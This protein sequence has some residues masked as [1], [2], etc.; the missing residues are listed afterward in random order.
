MSM[1]RTDQGVR[2]GPVMSIRDLDADLADATTR[3]MRDGHELFF[4]CG[5]FATDAKRD[6]ANSV[7]AG[8][9]W[10][11]IDCGSGK[12]SAGKGYES[13]EEV[14][15]ELRRFCSVTG[16]PA[17]THTVNSGGGV[18]CYWALDRSVDPQTWKA[19]AE[20][21]KA[22][23][24]A[25]RLLA[26][27]SRTAD[28][29]SLMRLPGTFN[30]KYDPP[31][32]VTVT[33]ESPIRVRFENMQGAIA[34]AFA[35]IPATHPAERSSA[36]RE[37]DRQPIGL[38]M[39]RSVI[40]KIDPDKE[41]PDW[42]KVLM[43]V[44]HETQ[45]SEEGL[46]LAID[47]SSKGNK[48]KGPDEVRAKWKTFRL[49]VLN[50][51]TI[52][53]LL[54]MAKDS[55]CFTPQETVVIPPDA[56]TDEAEPVNDLP[57]SAAAPFEA[58]GEHEQFAV[59]VPTNLNPLAKFSM[60]GSADELAAKLGNQKLVLGRIAL[61]GQLTVLYAPPN[62]GKTLLVLKLLCQAIDRHIVDPKKVFYLNMDDSGHGLVQKLHIAE[63]HGFEML[64]DGHQDFSA[65]Q[66]SQSL[67]NVITGGVANEMIV[68]L[69]TLKKFTD[70][71]D[72]R[73]SSEFAKQLR[74]FSAVGGTVIALAHTNKNRGSDGKLRHAGTSDILEDFDCSYIVD[75]AGVTDE[76]GCKVITLTN[77]KRR[78]DV[79]DE[80]SYRYRAGQDVRYLESL[81]SIE[82]VD[83]LTLR[84]THRQ[85]HV[86]QDGDHIEIVKA[87]L[88]ERPYKKME[89]ERDVR[90]RTGLTRTGVLELLERYVGDDPAAHHWRF[91]VRARGAMVYTLLSVAEKQRAA[92]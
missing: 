63:T 82:E 73:V 57:A 17:P 3:A 4:A 79:A 11:D 51:V 69:D 87:L 50:P 61:S 64:A 32:P 36:D 86:R 92:A 70:L 60:T 1:K 43:G 78:G 46:A 56:A 41:Y 71:M 12:A 42:V 68:V 55:E 75:S 49:D 85:R 19:T 9:F 48:Y 21:L 45:G 10:L 83:P 67:E 6:A 33:H 15:A 91:D 89:L 47:W 90:E 52:G 35:R 65:D 74:R 16:L 25:H 27:P 62:T 30:H 23:T 59:N 76:G 81:N 31:R 28:I 26:D 8:A 39:L 40:G 88:A 66:F 54:H 13:P 22:L 37:V 53:T 44:F 80:V 77:Q 72:K 34:D 58:F 2:V 38:S 18:H 29:A 20:Q 84:E 5:A 24:K 14:G 7:G